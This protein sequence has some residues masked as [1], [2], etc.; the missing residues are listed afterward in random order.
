M[1]FVRPVLLKTCVLYVVVTG[2]SVLP[3]TKYRLYSYDSHC[4]Y[5]N[6]GVFA[7]SLHEVIYW[8]RNICQWTSQKISHM[9]KS[10]TSITVLT[11]LPLG[12]ILG[13][14]NPFLILKLYLPTVLFDVTWLDLPSSL[15]PGRLADE[16]LH[17]FLISLLPAPMSVP[18]LCKI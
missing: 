10:W 7:L 1:N 3:L 17:T 14:M 18:W 5:V 11:R 13:Q 6:W 15:F 12:L 16:L 4:T 2:V 8:L 9:L